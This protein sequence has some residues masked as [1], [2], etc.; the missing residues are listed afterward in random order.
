MAQIN[1]EN[2]NCWNFAPKSNARSMKKG[3]K[4][5]KYK[6][7]NSKKML[8]KVIK[9]VARSMSFAICYLNEPFMR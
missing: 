2:I 7:Q 5:K 6:I 8:K 1:V 9:F 4:V 3:Q